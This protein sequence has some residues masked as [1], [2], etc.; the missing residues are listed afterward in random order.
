VSEARS[1]VEKLLK[2]ELEV[3]SL[4]EDCYAVW[5][6]GGSMVFGTGRRAR[7]VYKP[8]QAVDAAKRSQLK[9]PNATDAFA[10]L[11]TFPKQT[12]L[13]RKTASAMN[14]ANQKVMVVVSAARRAYRLLA[15]AGSLFMA[16]RPRYV[17]VIKLYTEQK[18]RKL[19]SVGDMSRQ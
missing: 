4:L 2:L 5:V 12:R 19:I 9:A 18:R 8:A 10:T 13:L 17:V 11:Q 1:T 3:R 6:I 14:P 15:I 16:A 7:K